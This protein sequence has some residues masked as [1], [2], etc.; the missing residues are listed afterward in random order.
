[1]RECSLLILSHSTPIDVILDGTGLAVHFAFR[2]QGENGGHRSARPIQGV[3]AGEYLRL[4]TSLIAPTRYAPVKL[5][6]LGTRRYNIVRE[7]G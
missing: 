3:R 1:M 4:M 6:G 5:Y 7:R 2:T